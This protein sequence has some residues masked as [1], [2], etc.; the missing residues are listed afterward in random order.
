MN[1]AAH[2]YAASFCLGLLDRYWHDN[3]TQEDGVE[4]I[5]KCLKEIQTRFLIS[6]PAFSV[7]IVDANG[8]RNIQLPLHA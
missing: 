8:A 4:L 5:S 6:T 7:K 2:G 1:I 3:I